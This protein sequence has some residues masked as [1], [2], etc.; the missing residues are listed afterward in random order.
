MV[1]LQRNFLVLRTGRISKSSS[2][3]ALKNQKDQN[4][5]PKEEANISELEET[6]YHELW[7][8]IQKNLF[9]FDNYNL[10]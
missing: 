6:K 9:L 2:A 5:N 1:S 4:F 10:M 8:E 3:T 7:K